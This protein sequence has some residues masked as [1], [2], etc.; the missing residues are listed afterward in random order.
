MNTNID[1]GVS[2]IKSITCNFHF[3][4]MDKI[5]FCLRQASMQNIATGWSQT[6][7]IMAELAGYQFKITN[8]GIYPREP[9]VCY[10]SGS[11]TDMDCYMSALSLFYDDFDFTKITTNVNQSGFD[12]INGTGYLASAMG[13]LMG[14]NFTSLNHNKNAIFK[15]ID[16]KSD[17]NETII[18]LDFGILSTTYD[19]LFTA[20]CNYSYI[21]EIND[22]LMYI[23]K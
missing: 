16:T 9:L 8:K 10:V 22:G 23:H 20:F 15:G 12:S 13:T 4:S 2:G 7:R 6:G 17:M 3:Q 5:M 1:N 11:G 18:D 21:L 14:Y 19:L